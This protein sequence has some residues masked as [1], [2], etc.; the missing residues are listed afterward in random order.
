MRPQIPELTCFVQ[1]N[2]DNRSNDYIDLPVNSYATSNLNIKEE[3]IDH[4]H[5]VPDTSGQQLDI[6]SDSIEYMANDLDDPNIQGKTSWTILES[7]INHQ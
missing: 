4:H 5:N 7:V 2:N 3:T 6:D 1:M